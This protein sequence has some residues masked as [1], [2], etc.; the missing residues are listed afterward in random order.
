MISYVF[1]PILPGSHRRPF[2]RSV[3]MLLRDECVAEPAPEIIVAAS[4]EVGL[5]ACLGQL[6]A[7]HAMEVL[8]VRGEVLAVVEEDTAFLAKPFVVKDV[9]GAFVAFPVVA[10]AEAH[11]AACEGAAVGSG[12]AFQVFSTYSFVSLEMGDW[13]TSTQCSPEF[14]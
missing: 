4:A 6:V 12:V 1:E 13:R 3:D 14:R 10:A 8:E 9:L 2:L 5:L 11:G 7:G